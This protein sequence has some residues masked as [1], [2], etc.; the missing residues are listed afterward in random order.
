M[1]VCVCVCVCVCSLS[2]C[3]II[4]HQVVEG[5]QGFHSRGVLHRDI[6]PENLL[7]ETGSETLRVRI[8]DLGCGCR[9]NDG[10]Y[11]QIKGELF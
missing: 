10:L 11:S 3:Q 9:Y 2:L 8:I 6:K 1:C 4:L 7:V 5:I